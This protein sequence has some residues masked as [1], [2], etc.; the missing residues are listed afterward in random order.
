M[1]NYVIINC[2]SGCALEA[3]L[4]HNQEPGK[5]CFMRNNAN[6]NSQRWKI[7]PGTGQAQGRGYSIIMADSGFCLDVEGADF[8]DEAD[9]ITWY[10]EGK[11]NQT[12]LIEPA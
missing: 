7:V 1:G 10:T 3:H 5:Q 8:H 6:Q 4:D 12:W 9:V 2:E 11:P